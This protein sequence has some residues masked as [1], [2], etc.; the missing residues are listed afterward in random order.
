MFTCLF[1]I[2]CISLQ[3]SPRSAAQAEHTA[4]VDALFAP[5]AGTA[6]P[7]AGVLVI[8]D[9]RVLLKRGY[10]LADLESGSPIEPNTAF[11]LGS[12]SKQFTAMAIMIL[13]E[14]GKLGYDDPLARF[15]P[16][17][18]AYARRITVRH[19]LNHTSG[20]QDYEELFVKTGKIP[21]NWPRSIKEPPDKYE[22]SAADALRLLEQ[23]TELRF[24][25][26]SKWEYSNS[27]Y[28]VLGQIVEKASGQRYRDFL[29]DD[30]FR[31]LGMTETAV[32]DETKPEIPKRAASYRQDGSK[33]PNIDY[34][35]LNGIYGEDNVV[36]TLNDMY[37]WDQALYTEALVRQS[38]LAQALTPGRLNDNSATDYG[39]GWSI[40]DR[41]GLHYV[42]HG[43]SW[44]GFRNFVLRYPL[45]HFSVVVLSNLAQFDPGAVANK[46]ARIYLQDQM[47]L[48]VEKHVSPQVLEEYVGEYQFRPRAAAEVTMEGGQLWIR[49]PHGR[50]QKLL[51]ESE[52]RFFVE[53]EEY[54]QVEFNR[55]AGGNVVSLTMLEGH[56]TAPKAKRYGGTQVTVPRPNMEEDNHEVDNRCRERILR[57]V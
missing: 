32:Y 53:G 39:F 51:A 33:F 23:Q 8:Q 50:R 22:P 13:A 54:V 46:I 5:W 4:E 30:I 6:T 43:G 1:S 21:A 20:L 31:P 38:T 27:G 12:V 19:L 42:E 14:R 3:G 48:P 2:L 34:T 49:L 35:P 26:G 25:P 7:G 36:S 10:G 28:M 9:G 57:G 17:F 55:D 24:Q 16:G 15:F 29:R 18:P 41:L 47:T 52:T 45:Q 44:L 56:R 11:L 37:K 40:G